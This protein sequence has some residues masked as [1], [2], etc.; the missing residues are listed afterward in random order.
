M[1]GFLCLILLP[2]YLMHSAFIFVHIIRR[3]FDILIDA[4]TEI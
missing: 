3:T 4:T 1:I 2:I